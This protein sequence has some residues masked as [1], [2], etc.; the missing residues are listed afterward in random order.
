MGIEVTPEAIEVLRRSLEF[1]GMDASAGG[2]RLRGARGLGGGFDVQVELAEGPL[3]GE[4][5]IERAGVRIFVDP[6]I[7]RA[8]PEAVVALEPQ[9]E[10]VVVRPADPSE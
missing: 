8:I 9:H 3:Q 10:I 4:E 6:E 1:A 2:V 7:T 5:E